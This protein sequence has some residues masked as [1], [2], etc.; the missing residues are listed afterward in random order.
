MFARQTQELSRVTREKGRA[1]A[2]RGRAAKRPML[3]VL[4]AMKDN[5]ISVSFSRAKKLH[6]GG[7]LN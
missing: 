3:D 7:V 1:D 5:L 6:E 4:P 2:A